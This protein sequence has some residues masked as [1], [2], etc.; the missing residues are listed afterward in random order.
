M[1]DLRYVTLEK[2]VNHET[3][4]EIINNDITLSQKMIYER[5]ALRNARRRVLELLKTRHVL[6]N[7]FILEYSLTDLNFERNL[8]EKTEE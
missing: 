8:G 5:I 7:M 1:M 3:R 2:L 4:R 6:N